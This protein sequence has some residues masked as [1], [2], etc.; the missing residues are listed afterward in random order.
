[1]GGIAATA[2]VEGHSAARVTSATVAIV[3]VESVL[4][5]TIVGATTAAA[6]LLLLALVLLLTTLAASCSM[7]LVGML[8]VLW[9]ACRGLVTKF[10][11][12][13]LDFPLH[14]IDGGV[15]VM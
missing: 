3:S 11:A 1:M 14:G 12:K 4:P 2:A 13:R 9:H 6:G 15:L 5:A 10:V 7:S 8:W